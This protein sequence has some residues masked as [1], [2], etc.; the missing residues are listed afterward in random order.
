MEAANIVYGLRL[1]PAEPLYPD[2]QKQKGVSRL[3]VHETTFLLGWLGAWPDSSWKQRVGALPLCGISSRDFLPRWEAWCNLAAISGQ[4]TSM[5]DNLHPHPHSDSTS[6]RQA[7]PDHLKIFAA[8][9][10]VKGHVNVYERCRFHG[11]GDWCDSPHTAYAVLTAAF[12]TCLTMNIHVIALHFH[13]SVC[14]YAVWCVI[15]IKLT[16]IWHSIY[17]KIDTTWIRQMLNLTSTGSFLA[18]GETPTSFA[19]V[20]KE[21]N[22]TQKRLWKAIH[23]CSYTN[24]SF[25]GRCSNLRLHILGLFRLWSTWLSRQQ[26]FH[27]N[28]Q[29][30]QYRETCWL[31]VEW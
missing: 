4:W 2:V 9:V 10:F 29:G 1:H 26:H 30:G 5:G 23:V 6:L 28:T 16:Y 11:N 7:R 24:N 22:K 18:L 20:K 12:L 17:L 31:H 15:N 3:K 21:Q 27:L 8:V 13:I 25:A 14:V 19:W